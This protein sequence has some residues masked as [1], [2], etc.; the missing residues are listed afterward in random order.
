M[1]NDR[2]SR[3]SEELQ[4]KHHVDVV[5]DI[6]LGR[7]D[8]VYLYAEK[9]Q[10]DQMVFKV[11][12]G[13]LTRIGFPD[14]D[15]IAI[16]DILVHFDL[17]NCYAAVSGK[18][19]YRD[20]VY[21]ELTRETGEPNVT[22]PIRKDGKRYWL[23]ILMYPVVK[24]PNILCVSITD[25]TET[26]I[27]EELN[28]DRSHRDS[29]TGLFNKYTL[30]FHYGLRYR[31]PG[32]HAVYLDLDDFKSVNDLCG[33]AK[34]DRFLDAFA[35]ILKTYHLGNDLFYRLGGDE[36]IGLCF[37]TEKKMRKMAAEIIAKT[38]EIKIDALH[39]IPSVSI[40]IVRAVAC[41]D[42]VHKADRVMYMVKNAG[43]NGYRY[44]REDA[45][46][47]EPVAK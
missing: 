36:F 34:G 33:H 47:A 41:E 24:H 15:A 1:G 12:S 14:G 29:L 39:R 38:H 27:A 44:E 10:L 19:A 4:K 40:G 20:Y 2:L 31:D 21:G 5:A 18:E 22:F 30:D 28:Y 32:F 11:I 7:P 42:V 43:K 37:G 17:D 9:A 45:L 25:L 26:M 35:A 23:H 3:V 16:K 6:L 46:S 13:S 8:R